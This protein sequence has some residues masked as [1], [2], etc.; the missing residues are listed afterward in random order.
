M[1]CISTWRISSSV[2]QITF[3]SQP[4]LF[5][6]LITSSEL[7]PK[8]NAFSAPTSSTIS[9]LAPSM[10]P[11]VGAPLSINFILP[12][13]EASLLAV[14]ICSDTSAAAK[15]ISALDTRQFSINTT[16]IFPL[17]EASLFTTSATELIS[18]MIFLAVAQPADAF[19][20]KI[21]VLG[22][23]SISGCILIWLY[24]QI[25]WRIFNS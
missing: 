4:P 10:V 12:V 11:S 3:G 14:E 2:L 1:S 17:I 20:P 25:T 5:S 19:A 24:R 22:Q 13:P 21:K 7:K 6:Q 9:T 16:L 18:L 23:N 8:I 15:I